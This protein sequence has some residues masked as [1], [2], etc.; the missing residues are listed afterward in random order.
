MTM[1]V[2]KKDGAAIV[3][4]SGRLD[5]STTGDFETLML[6][7]LEDDV[8]K[9]IVDFSELVYINSSGLRVLVMTFQRLSK[10]GG[11]LAVCGLQDYIHEVFTISGYDMLLSVYPT[12]DE[13]LN[14]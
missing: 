9:I 5:A 3:T 7:L 12:V 13:A 11:K 2:E 6:G 8:K 10:K 4:V 14:D 1:D